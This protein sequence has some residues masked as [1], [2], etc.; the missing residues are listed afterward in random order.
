MLT[1]QSRPLSPRYPCP[2]EREN[3]DLKQLFRVKQRNRHARTQSTLK[4]N[5][6][7]KEGTIYV[8]LH[9]VLTVWNEDSMPQYHKECH[10][11]L[12]SLSK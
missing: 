7:S 10:I 2:A 6:S 8:I 12:F 5:M 3:D 9:Q 11:R 1:K 4:N